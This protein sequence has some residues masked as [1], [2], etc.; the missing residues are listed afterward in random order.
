MGHG[1]QMWLQT[2]W[3]LTRS[4]RSPTIILDEPDVYMHADLQRRIIR[5]LK[6]GFPQVLLTTHSVEIMSEVQP[7]D[8]LIIDRNSGQSAPAASVPAVQSLIDNV[9]SAHNIQFARL[10]NAR[11]FILIE[12]EDLGILKQIQNILFPDSEAPIDTIPNMQIGG[13][14][15]W[16]YVIGS[17][18]ML[19][20]SLGEKVTT[21][22]LLDSGYHTDTAID[23][24][25]DEA[26][27]HGIQ[28]HVWARKEIESYLLVPTAIHRLIEGRIAKR[29]SPR[30]LLM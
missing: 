24:R 4:Q 21:Y 9:G 28:L 20:N 8:I 30:L 14:G 13:W 17:T 25:I 27:G 29:T 1:L 15:G 5:F 11:K 19:K 16:P 12:G 6:S 7:E 3:F 10:W 2:M 18:M 22:C 23:A 26:K